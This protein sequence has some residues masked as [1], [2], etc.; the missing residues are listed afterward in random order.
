MDRA[1]GC[2][3]APE[4]RSGRRA[5]CAGGPAPLE[6]AHARGRWARAA[7]AG[8]GDQAKGGGGGSTA[9]AAGAHPTGRSPRSPGHVGARAKAEP[10]RGLAHARTATD[11]AGHERGG[12]VR[13]H[14]VSTARPRRTSRRVREAERRR[15]GGGSQGAVG[16]GATG[17]GA[18]DGDNGV[19]DGGAVR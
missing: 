17:L 14:G 3:R 19:V 10:G 1:F 7:H 4:G 8:A 9:V 15:G 2:G 16:F 18:E 11:V 12:G 5:P 13:E 6:R